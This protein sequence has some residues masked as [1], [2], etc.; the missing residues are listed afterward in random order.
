[1]P[2]VYLLETL[3]RPSAWID[4]AQGLADAINGNGTTIINKG[5]YA[6]SRDLERSAVSC[7]DQHPFTTPSPETVVD[8]LLEVYQNVSRFAF[9]FFTAEPDA[10]CQYWSIPP[11]PEQFH[12]PWNHTL[13]NP[14]LVVSNTVRNKCFV[15]QT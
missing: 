9:A 1:M 12:G 10:G 4:N 13:R 5:P 11:P 8:A 14:I 2:A 6:A 7:N 3:E 15:L